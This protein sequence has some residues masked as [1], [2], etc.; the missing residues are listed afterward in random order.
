M[1]AALW[2]SRYRCKIAIVDSGEYRNRWTQ[3]SHG[4]LGADP[5]T[6]TG[7]RER[8][9]RDL[10]RYGT[11]SVVDTQAVDARGA[12][13][14]FAVTLDRGDELRARRLVL[15]TGVRDVFPDVPRF[16]DHYGSRIFHCPSCDG[17]EAKD[18]PVVAFGWS[19]E[20]A[21]FA[22]GLLQWASS[23]TVV[24]DGRRFEGDERHRSAL[25]EAGVGVLTDEVVELCGDPGELCAVRLRHGGVVP[26]TYAFFSIA[27]EPRNDLAAALGCALTDEGCVAVDDDG[28]TSVAGV[29][30][31][32]DLT[33]GLQYVQVAAA[34]GALAGTN[35]ALSLRGDDGG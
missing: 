27:H 8:A 11:A 25:A 28:C 19:A 22:R 15:A 35:C 3:A 33:P 18:Q 5:D 2:L 34:K 29:Y 10:D 23:V 6:P 24:T 20:V 21:G 31:A 4:Y 26:C 17:Y 32:G 7:L 13:G 16:F 1:T 14:G 9:L 12:A 30:A